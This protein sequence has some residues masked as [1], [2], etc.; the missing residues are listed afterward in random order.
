MKETELQKET[1]RYEQAGDG[2]EQ[3]TDDRPGTPDGK[4]VWLRRLGSL[5]MVLALVMIARRLYKY[6]AALIS[7]ITV[8]SV[9]A[10]VLFMLL[11]AA[12]ILFNSALY[13]RLIRVITGKALPQE[14]VSHLYTKSNLYKYL[15]GNVMHLIGRNQIAAY[16]QVPHGDIAFCT[17]L[18]LAIT[19]L[20]PAIVSIIFS[21]KMVITWLGAHPGTIKWICILAAI[22]LACCAAILVFLKKK[23]SFAKWFSR[24]RGA[25][26]LMGG[27]VICYALWNALMGAA[28]LLLL[29]TISPE[30]AWTAH[31]EIIGIFSFSWLIGFITPGAPGGLGIREA[32]LMFFL[33]GIASADAVTSAAMINRIASIFG[34][35]L[36]YGIMIMVVWIA[37]R[38]AQT[39]ENS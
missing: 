27:M 39:K 33:D 29:K 25:L 6:R 22:A 3:M 24:V 35:M 17:V 7:A 2:V 36:A 30:L 18:E 26:P 12:Y 34:D 9:L 5:L 14:V 1:D 32:I 21:W 20:G 16:C 13:N 23:G 19:C 15:P 28:F 11:Q 37:K 38:S 8:S 31:L 4:K 10:G